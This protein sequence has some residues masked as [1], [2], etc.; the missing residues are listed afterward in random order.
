[1]NYSELVV[2]VVVAFELSREII[3][4]MLQMPN[5]AI[6]SIKSYRMLNTSQTQSQTLHNL[7]L[8]AAQAAELFIIL[9][10]G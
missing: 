6:K 10:G 4:L 5:N 9:V 3:K 2:V 1:M 8:N 7:H